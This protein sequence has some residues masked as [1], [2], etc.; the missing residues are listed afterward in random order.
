MNDSEAV[1][2]GPA[3]R[4]PRATGL[5]LRRIVAEARPV[6]DMTL[7]QE[8]IIALLMESEDGLSSTELARL[9]G[10]RA[11]TMSAA[12]MALDRRGLISGSADP[13]DKRRT[14][15]HATPTGIAALETSLAAKQQWLESALEGF[16]PEE[17][18][19][20]DSA[21]TLMERLAGA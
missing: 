16:T 4:L 1:A 18:A 20:L 10:V 14:I 5:L 3:R 8:S 12:V 9:E 17:L 15:L 6:T 2:R 21:T 13:N 11:Q 7:S 19:T